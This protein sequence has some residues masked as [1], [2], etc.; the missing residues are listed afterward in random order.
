MRSVGSGLAA[1]DRDGP[2]AD[3]RLTRPRKRNALTVDLVKDL[4]EAFRRV[5]A[6]E[7]IRAI[8]LLG[9]GPA[10][11]AG[12]DLEE[13]RAA[14]NVST[15]ADE[16]FPQ[17][18]RTIE[19]VRQPVIAGI[20]GAAPGTAFEL[21]LACDLRVLG[22]DAAYGLVETNLGIFP[23]G[24]GTQRLPRLI[25]RSKATE[26]VLT[27][28]YIAPEEAETIGLVH[29]VVPTDQVEDR[30]T[31]VA[32]DLTSKAPRALHHAKRALHAASDTPL[33]QGLAYERA[34]GR[35]LQESA[36]FR[37]GIEAQLDERDGDEE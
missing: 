1:I 15:F 35:E 37:E 25:G 19:G 5:G 21:T 29:H 28:E 16:V 9:E 13:V 4:T 3:V 12:V 22:A 7:K 11:S 10:F 8:T 34:L 6:D 20:E 26:L 2:R 36:A 27:G 33:E 31:A 17:L 30:A 32:D 18:L 14:S 23:Q 24:G